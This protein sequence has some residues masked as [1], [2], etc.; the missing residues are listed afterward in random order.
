MLTTLQTYPTIPMKRFGTNLY[1]EPLYRIVWSDSRT[2]LIGGR[3]PDGAC[4]YRES[5]RYAGLHA[6]VLEKWMSSV[7]YAGTPQEYH[8]AQWDADSGL[9]TC[10]PYPSRGEYVLCHVFVGQPSNRAVEKQIYGLKV[11]RDLTPGQRKQGIMDPLEKQE[12]ERNERFD[13]IFDQSM[14]PFSTADAVVGFGRAASPAGHRQGFK[15]AG[16]MPH[17]RTDQSAPLPTANNFFGQI[18]S[19]ETI[20]KLTGDTHA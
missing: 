20:E 18:R 16:D 4:E 13:Q 9:L 15:R 10:G 2:D 11:S 5:P 7:E 17:Q 3:W 14:G 1:E 19:N 12:R 8:A 6:W